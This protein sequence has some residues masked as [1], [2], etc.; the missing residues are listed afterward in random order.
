MGFQRKHP[1]TGRASTNSGSRRLA[2]RTRRT[3]Y[4]LPNFALFHGGESAT[5]H[6]QLSANYQGK[7]TL[8]ENYNFLRLNRARN[9]YTF[10]I[11][12]AKRQYQ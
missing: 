5:I 10:T 1:Y 6:F 12:S 8:R 7:Y 9:Q 11:K 3:R 4:A 2:G